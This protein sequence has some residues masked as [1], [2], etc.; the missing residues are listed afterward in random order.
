MKGKLFD[1]KIN[2]KGRG[3]WVTSMQVGE[4]VEGD[5]TRE[6]LISGSRDKTLMIWDI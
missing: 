6:F 4:I 2:F 1:L 5:Q 3:G